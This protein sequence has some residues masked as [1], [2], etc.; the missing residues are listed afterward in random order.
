MALLM[1]YL[2]TQLTRKSPNMTIL[3]I[4]VYYIM[5]FVYAVFVDI[6]HRENHESEINF[7]FVVIFIIAYVSPP[8]ST[9]VQ[10]YGGVLLNKLCWLDSNQNNIPKRSSKAH[11]L[12]CI[13]NHH[14]S[15]E[16]L[17]NRKVL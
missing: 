11:H 12:P 6:D 8:Q 2:S 15:I 4:L 5:C 7:Y 17:L 10:T 3:T 1:L 16:S 14:N 9:H 13:C